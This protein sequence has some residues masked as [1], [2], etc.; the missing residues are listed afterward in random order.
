MMRKGVLIAFSEIG[1]RSKPVRRRLMGLLR[2]NIE[3]GLRWLNIEFEEVAST[4]DRLFVFADEGEEIAALVKDVPGVRFTAPIYYHEAADVDA[5]LRESLGS[6]LREISGKTFKVETKRRDKS[7]PLNSMEISAVV[8]EKLL[9]ACERARVRLTEPEVTVYIEIGSHYSLLYTRRFEGL[10]GYP[11]GA[12]SPLVVLLSGG[13]DSAA[14]MWLVLHRGCMVYPLFINQ[15]PFTGC[16]YIERAYH[17]FKRLKERVMMPDMRL[18]TAKVGRLMEEIVLNVKPSNICVHCKRV[19]MRVA[20]GYAQRV[21]AKGIVT[22]E[23]IGQVASQTIDNLFVISMATSLPIYRPLAGMS[24]EMI[25]ELAKRAGIYE[26]SA[27]SI[28]YCDILPPHPTTRARL[29]EIEEE[30][31]ELGIDGKVREIIEE[32]EFYSAT[33]S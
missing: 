22:G 1:I 18:A 6:L 30:E 12:Q 25:H 13:T 24:K 26:I 31:K 16:C 7:F 14:A 23:S 28:P 3:R 27:R 32:I 5:L 10:G 29:E 8:G 33:L 21:G 20:E 11:I 17:I 9:A 4:W 15:S 2:R 19:M